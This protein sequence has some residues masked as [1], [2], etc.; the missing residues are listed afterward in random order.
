MVYNAGFAYDPSQ[1]IIVSR[2]D[3]WQFDYG[4]C[5]LYDE[6]SPV[7]IQ[8]IIDCEPIRFAHGG[9]EWMIELWKGQYGFETGAEVGVYNRAV[10]STASRAISTAFGIV[11]P[12]AAAAAEALNHTVDWYPSAH[13]ADWLQISFTLTKNGATLFR[14]GPE[15]HW[16][17]TGFR[18]GE[19]SEP[20]DLVADIEITIPDAGVRQAFAQA[21]PKQHA[22][23][24]PARENS[25]AFRF[26][27]PTMPQPALRASLHDRVMESNA[28]LVNEYLAARQ[29]LQVKTNNPNDLGDKAGASDL[30]RSMVGYFTEVQACKAKWD[31]VWA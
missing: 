11:F 30:L 20:G 31:K 16:W 27:R 4:F 9:K 23:L 6:S 12:L 14:R 10:A 29:R 8:A 13:K 25:V 2:K 22:R 19:L 26:A 21:L 5:R 28:R 7:S 17:L 15:S 3:A 18:W 24:T 1:D